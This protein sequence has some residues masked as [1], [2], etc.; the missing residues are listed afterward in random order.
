MEIQEAQIVF[1]MG[2]V[3]LLIGSL[4]NVRQRKNRG[5]DENYN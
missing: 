2:L 4:I 5:H 1:A 3:L